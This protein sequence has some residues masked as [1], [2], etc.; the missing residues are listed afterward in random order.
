MH[1]RKVSACSLC[2]ANSLWGRT[3]LPAQRESQRAVLKRAFLSGITASSGC[4]KHFVTPCLCREEIVLWQTST[5]F[6]S[7]FIRINCFLS[8]ELFE[9][10]LSSL[11]AR[12]RGS[13]EKEQGK[14][15]EAQ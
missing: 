9:V 8:K 1:E 10:F 3:S 14:G 5:F 15:T 4:K 6:F 7:F 13:E 2:H 11:S 12:F